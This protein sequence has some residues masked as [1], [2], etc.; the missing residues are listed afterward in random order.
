MVAELTLPQLR[1]LVRRGEDPAARR[2]D[3][4]AQARAALDRF[5]SGEM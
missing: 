1:C 5:R 2:R 3:L 4:A